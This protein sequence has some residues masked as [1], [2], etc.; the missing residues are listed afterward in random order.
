MSLTDQAVSG[1]K[2]SGAAT[3]ARAG[4]QVICVAVL[5]R[6]LAPGDFGLLSMAAIVTGLAQAFSDF[7]LSNAIIYRQDVSV[8]QLSSIYWINLFIGF[9]IF[10]ALWLAT[11]L[12]VRY[13]Q[14]SRLS[15]VLRWSAASFLVV[16]VGQQYQ[17]LLR[18]NMRF[19]ELSLIQMVEA[20]FYAL[21][22]VGL[23]LG[24]C[25]V[26]SLVWG[27]LL[28]S[29][30]VAGL[31]STI[32]VHSHWLPIL[33]FKC[34][35]LKGFV[36]FGLFQMGERTVNYLAT[37]VDYLIIGRFLGPESLGYY[38]LAYSL[39]TVPLSYINP[40]IV[41]VAFPAFA[42][43]QHEDGA[44]RNGYAKILHYL[45]TATFPLMA[46]LFV[47]SPILI[48]LLY[49]PQWLPTVEVIQVFCFLGLLKSFGNPIG[50]LLMAKG[51]VDLGFYMN[52][53]AIIGYAV[54]NMIGI[55]WSIKGVAVSSLI[56]SFLILLPIDLYL[57]RLIIN[58]KF[59]ESWGAVRLPIFS[60]LTM[61]VTI[62]PVYYAV[63]SLDPSVGLIVLVITGACV[64]IT[65]LRLVDQQFFKDLLKLLRPTTLSRT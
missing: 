36:R 5:A 13:Y 15:S 53:I 23:A 43:V 57:R 28:R 62:L 4:V 2:W 45:S 42:R 58:M 18:K 3:L 17:S 59:G 24:G 12:V 16:P 56:F 54:S 29:A 37:N 46:G 10:C 25:G 50:S 6:L 7:G 33:R 31:L 27:N 35:D 63:R 60:T 48:P 22:S 30:F 1:A 39:M 41:S 8:K 32:A 21:C 51:R 38:T 20:A 34:S 11:P 19:K 49:G 61:L 64:Y 55:R 52:V 44:L 26:M 40:M 65:A 47:V 9:S 14:E